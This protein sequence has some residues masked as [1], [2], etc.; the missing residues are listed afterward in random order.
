M[1]SFFSVNFVKWLRRI[2]KNSF[3]KIFGA[4]IM[5]YFIF[6]QKNEQFSILFHFFER[7]YRKSRTKNCWSDSRQFYKFM[8][9]FFL[10]IRQNFSIQQIFLFLKMCFS[11]CPI[12]QRFF[13]QSAIFRY[14]ET[15]KEK[16]GKKEHFQSNARR[17]FVDIISSKCAAPENLCSSEKRDFNEEIFFRHSL[18]S[19]YL[20]RWINAFCRS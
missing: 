13:I 20:T 16:N 8:A 1:M 18:Y 3:G 5:I 4:I 12:G 14:L 9:Q 2:I 17:D 6:K 15:Q 10:P 19:S 11:S 7:F